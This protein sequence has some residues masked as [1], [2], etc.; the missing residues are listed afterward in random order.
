MENMPIE[1]ERK[2]QKLLNICQERN[3]TEQGK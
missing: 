3:M 1:T 2:A